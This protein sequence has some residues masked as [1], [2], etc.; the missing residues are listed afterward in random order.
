MKI[1]FA[2]SECTPFIKTG[3]LADVAGTLPAALA[4][5][6]A[7]ARVILPKYRDIPQC[8]KERM[9][10]LLSFYVNLGWRRQYCG[11]DYI[12][13]DGVTYY[14]VD[15]EFYFGRDKVYGS[16]QEEGERFGFFCR[17]V[18]E[19]LRH[20]G[21]FPDV[22]HCNDWQT[23]MIPAL[24]KMQY[25]GDDRY[26]AVKTVYTIHNLRYQG[27]FSWKYIE[28]LL[29]IEERYYSPDMLEYYGCLS[30]MKAGVV[31]GDEITT[32][33]PT[34]AGEIQTAYYG[35]KLDGLMRARSGNL[36]GILN[37][38]NPAEYNPADDMWLPVHFSADDLSGKALCKADLQREMGLE[39]RPDVPLIGMITRLCDQKG[40]DLVECVLDD[41]MQRD[42]QIMLLGK[43][44]EHYQDLFSW[45]AWRYQGRLACRIELNNPLSHRIYAACDMLLMPSQFEPCGLTQM[46]AMRYGTI[47]IVRETGGLK[48]SVKPYNKYEDSGN[49]FSFCNYNAHEMLAKIDD[50][51][52]YYRQ[53]EVWERLMLR[54][55]G[56]DFSWDR[57]AQKYM[58]L[59]EKLTGLYMG[60][61]QADAA[62]EEFFDAGQETESQAEEPL[63]AENNPEEL[64]VRP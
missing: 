35:E 34:Y 63:G 61:E 51:I 19:T 48:D 49:G 4:R 55:M 6:G 50:A 20:I 59:Y 60:A 58:E 28:E 3:G 23:G 47:P 2:A 56:S 24:L 17:A 30:F 52:G 25:Q 42:V 26:R 62:E 39:V 14:F 41:I 21:F 8:W 27:L 64:V 45:A 31:F 46:I 44:D 12:E 38:I 16:G 15:N 32:V 22:L 53:G 10:S 36:S 40:L 54:A 13:L 7:D 29:G 33:S 11:I 43:G 1:L 5:A 9:R 37:G 18:L 57:S